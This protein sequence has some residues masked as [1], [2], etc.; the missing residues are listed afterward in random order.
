MQS[1]DRQL[2]GFLAIALV[3]VF[4]IYLS[5]IPRSGDYV[6]D[7]S[8]MPGIADIAPAA[9]EAVG[10]AVPGSVADAVVP[11][12][13]QEPVGLEKGAAYAVTQIF[14]NEQACV[15]ATNRACH[16]VQCE[17]DALPSAQDERTERAV[18]NACADNEKTGWRS[19]VPAPDKTAIPEVVAPPAELTTE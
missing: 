12:V 8:F 7:D 14:D 5:A 18:E 16:F 6:A 2:L 9:G 17:N 4:A 1:K 15:E 3:A 10:S 11:T 13:P 19:I